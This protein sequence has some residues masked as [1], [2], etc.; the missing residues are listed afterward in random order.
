MAQAAAAALLTTAPLAAQAPPAAADS[1]ELPAIPAVLAPDKPCT[2]AS[3]ETARDEPWTRRALGLSR[4]WGL[5]DG[6]GVTVGVVDSGV[7]TDIPALAGR[8]TAVGGAG[9][10]C[11]G[12]GSFAAGLIA[13]APGKGSGVAGAAPAA[14]ILAVRGTDT[15]GNPTAEQLATGIRAAVD[16][17]AKVVYVGRAVPTGKAALTAAVAYA[18]SGRPGRRSVRPGRDPEDPETGQTAEPA[19]W[20]WPARTRGAVGHRLRPGRHPPGERAAISGADL[21]APGTPWSASGQGLR[22]LHRLRLLAGGGDTSR[23]RRRWCV[24]GIRGCPR[25]R[26]PAQLVTAAAIRRFTPRLD[27]YAGGRPPSS[28]TSRAPRPARPPRQIPPAASPQPLN[29]ALMIAGAGGGV[30]LLVA[31]AAVVI[32]RGRARGSPAGQEDPPAV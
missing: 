15:R 7:G 32:P 21:A 3:G 13:A 5:A 20:Y 17:G 30:V 8:V 24:P 27:P 10:D 2:K 19:P 25:P 28:P 6:K 1:V 31:A 11:V 14:R 16:G 26:S 29:R 9:T 12:H 23:G 18:S 22:P 4:A